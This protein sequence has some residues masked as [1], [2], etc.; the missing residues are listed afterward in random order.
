M[1]AILPADAESLGFYH[2]QKVKSSSAVLIPPAWI[3]EP[4]RVKSLDVFHGVAI[5]GMI[6]VNNPGDW[7]HTYSPLDHAPWNGCMQRP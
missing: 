6:L 4:V 7:A 5:A 3:P 2:M 1:L